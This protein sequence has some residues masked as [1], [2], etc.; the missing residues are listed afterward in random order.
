MQRYVNPITLNYVLKPTYLAALH[1]TK[2]KDEE[3]QQKLKTFEEVSQKVEKKINV[4]KPWFPSIKALKNYTKSFEIKIIYK[5]EPLIPIKYNS[6]ID[7]V[8]SL[9]YLFSKNN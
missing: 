6:T 9:N 2:K 4:Q 3:W 1:K 5:N 7:S 8:A